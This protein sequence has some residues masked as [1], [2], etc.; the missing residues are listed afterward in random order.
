MVQAICIEAGGL[1][2]LEVLLIHFELF[3]FQ[4]LNA[5]Q[6]PVLQQQYVI[7]WNSLKHFELIASQKDPKADLMIDLKLTKR[8]MV[9][10]VA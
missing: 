10:W 2:G 5:F 7:V 8:L 4:K 1:G 6:I 9:R 3:D